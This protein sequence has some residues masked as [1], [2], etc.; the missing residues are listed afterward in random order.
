MSLF[1]LLITIVIVGLIFA[2]LWW[3]LRE[4]SLP[5]P[6][7]KVAHVILV[8]AVVIFLVG[9]LTGQVPMIKLG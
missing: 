2:V 9:I 8:L 3:G 5:E 1:S 6:F 4:I 7:A